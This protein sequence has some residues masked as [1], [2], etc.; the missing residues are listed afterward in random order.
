MLPE[1]PPN[2][3]EA[4]DLEILADYVNA[5]ADDR[6]GPMAILGRATEKNA[7]RG[8]RCCSHLAGVG[9]GVQTGIGRL[10]DHHSHASLAGPRPTGSPAPP[11]RQPANHANRHR[12]RLG[13]GI[14]RRRAWLHPILTIPKARPLGNMMR[15]SAGPF[16]FQNG[17]KVNLP[18]FWIDKYEV[19]I[20]SYAE[21]LDAI[22]SSPAKFDHVEQPKSKLGHK[23]QNWDEWDHR[24]AREGALF[25]GHSITVNCPVLWSIGGMHTPTPLGRGVD[26]LPSWSG[27][28]RPAV[29]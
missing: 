2:E 4:A 21:F 13:A 17:D 28:R 22:S 25:K 10:S 20:A 19:S 29:S 14:G 23:P 18:E 5:I 7:R 24:A 11:T 9:A 27:K 8:S 15:I 12:S 1:H 3:D 16:I 6:P 26:C